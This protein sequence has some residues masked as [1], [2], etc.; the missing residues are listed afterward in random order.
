MALIDIEYGSLA[1]SETMNKNFMY[2]DDK[3]AETSESIMTSISSILSNIATINSRLNDIT[4]N[5]EDSVENLSTN[6][7][8]Y[9]AK[10]KM[11]VNKA[12]MVPNW[13]T[14]ASITLTTTDTYTVP[15]NGFLLL[16]PNSTL[17]GNLTINGVSVVFKNRASNYDNASQLVAIPV[18]DGDQVKTDI[19]FTNVYFLPSKEIIIEN[20]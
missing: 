8:E 12:S 5:V 17:K 2:L 3:I 10:T 14:C 7:E 6:L 19:T 4:E 20:F 11:L 18:V 15:S 1:S 16:V 13:A 9:K